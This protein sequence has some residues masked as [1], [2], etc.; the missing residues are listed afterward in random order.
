M[1]R[2]NIQEIQP[3][4]Y[5]AMFG[6]ESYIAE[7]TIEKNLQELVRL[8]ASLLNGCKFCIGMHTEAASKLGESQDR[9]SNL[10]NWHESSLYSDKEKSALSAT[11][12]ITKI[13][14]SGLTSETYAKLQS[15]FSDEE[16]AQLIMLCSLINTWNRIGISMDG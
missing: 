13:S 2:V 7:S 5:Q 1:S 4:A 10:T 3:G 8:R 9:I 14:V 12:E 11:D 15:H 16:I 6:L